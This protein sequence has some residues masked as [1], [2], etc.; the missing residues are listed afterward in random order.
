M[1]TRAKNNGDMW[2]F[3]EFSSLVHHIHQHVHHICPFYPYKTKNP[4]ACY[5]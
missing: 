4:Q 5:T 1:L 2:A 3:S